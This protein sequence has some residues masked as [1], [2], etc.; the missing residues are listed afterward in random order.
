MDNTAIN[1]PQGDLLRVDLGSEALP[2]CP[3]HMPSLSHGFVKIVTMLAEV[4]SI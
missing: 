3:S 4:R 1:I 2:D